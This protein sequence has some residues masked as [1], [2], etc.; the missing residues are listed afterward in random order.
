MMG[1]RLAAALT[2]LAVGFWP[3]VSPAEDAFI[4]LPLGGE[5]AGL[6][7]DLSVRPL[8]AAEGDSLKLVVG[9]AESGDALLQLPSANGLTGILPGLDGLNA[10]PSTVGS[11][12]RRLDQELLNALFAES[13]PAVL[14]H[15]TGNL[16]APLPGLERSS[17]TTLPG[18]DGLPIQLP[19]PRD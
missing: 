10:S 5:G 2:V 12:V 18:I 8:L 1:K 4:S 3:A 17:A 14:S 15:V 16:A 19:P 6:S 11:V 13:D 7:L 9:R